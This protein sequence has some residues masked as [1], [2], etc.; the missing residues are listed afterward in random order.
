M[1]IL[2]EAT[3]NIEKTTMRN[4][5]PK[6]ANEVAGGYPDPKQNT[7]SCFCDP[8]TIPTVDAGDLTTTDV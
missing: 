4:L 8:P 5:T 7:I 1:K 2:N 6:E 3:F